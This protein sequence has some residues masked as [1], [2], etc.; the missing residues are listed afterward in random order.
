MNTAQ[1]TVVNNKR[2]KAGKP[3]LTFEQAAMAEA[4]WREKRPKDSCLQYLAAWVPE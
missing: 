3:P 2:E 4:I 1:L